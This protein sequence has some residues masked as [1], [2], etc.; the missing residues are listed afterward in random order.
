MLYNYNTVHS[1]AVQLAERLAPFGGISLRVSGSRAN[2]ALIAAGSPQL[3]AHIVA[4]RLVFSLFAVHCSSPLLLSHFVSIF[5]V[6]CWSILSVTSIVHY[7]CCLVYIQYRTVLIPRKQGNC[8]LQGVPFEYRSACCSLSRRPAR[9]AT[10]GCALVR[11]L[12]T[13]SVNSGF[14]DGA[15]IIAI[16]L[17]WTPADLSI[18]TGLGSPSLLH[19]ARSPSFPGIFISPLLLTSNTPYDLLFCISRSHLFTVLIIILARVFSPSDA[20]HIRSLIFLSFFIRFF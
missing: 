8:N 18:V 3:Y 5:V 4:S 14:M 9:R 20:L 7:D 10:S 1:V 12:T 13:S 19:C 17:E 15:L 16:C 2:E 6:L 11:P